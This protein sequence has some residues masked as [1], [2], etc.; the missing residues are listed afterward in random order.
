MTTTNYGAK[1]C[2]LST[3][4][5]TDRTVRSIQHNRQNNGNL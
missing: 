2:F 5:Q 1:C 4:R 3:D